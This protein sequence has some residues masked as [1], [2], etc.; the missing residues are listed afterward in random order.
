M[1]ICANYCGAMWGSK[2]RVFAVQLRMMKGGKTVLVPIEPAGAMPR[3]PAEGFD[4]VADAGPVKGFKAVD[5]NIIPG[6]NAG[7]YAWLSESVH[8]NLY[9][10]PLQ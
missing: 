3:L 9:R 2:G 10:I 4:P 7:Q 6:P 5:K 8:R 1:R